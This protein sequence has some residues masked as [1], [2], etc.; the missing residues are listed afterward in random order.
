MILGEYAV[1]DG[2]P[3]LVLAI[4][5]GVR[6]EATLGGDTIRIET[7][8]GDTRF[9]RPALQGAPSGRYRFSAWNP[10][11]LPG[12]PG[13][14]GSAAACVAACAVA[15]RP[16]TDALAIHHQVQGSGS[17]IDVAASI[18][19]GMLRFEAGRTTPVAPVLPVVVYSGASA[20]TGPRVAAYRAWTPRGTFVTDTQGVVDAFHADPIPAL[21]AGFQLLDAMADAARLDWATPALRTIRR[22]ARALG[23][24][25]KPSG[26]GGGDCAIALLPDADR[27]RRF[28]ADCAAVGLP[29][30][31]VAVASGAAVRRGQP[32]G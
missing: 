6:C 30:I 3:A 9:T 20:Q 18:Q 5:R 1:L 15:R 8:T 4:D 28:I 10:V 29:V 13:F 27:R 17:G 24:A 2:A 19:G 21:E 23:G 22:L 32:S 26:A 25:A 11:S 16:L 12:K 7:P 14:G 31:P